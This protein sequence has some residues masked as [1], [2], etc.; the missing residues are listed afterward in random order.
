MTQKEREQ[1]FNPTYYASLSADDKIR[2]LE[3]NANEGP[4][5]RD[6]E[7]CPHCGSGLLFSRRNQTGLRRTDVYPAPQCMT[8]GW[9]LLQSGSMGMEPEGA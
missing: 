6:A 5:S 1:R 7:T 8:C 2:Y 3:E 9:P 4:G